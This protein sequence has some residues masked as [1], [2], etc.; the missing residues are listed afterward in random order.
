MA[1]KLKT[2]D[3]KKRYSLWDKETVINYINKSFLGRYIGTGKTAGIE[4]AGA[5]KRYTIYGSKKRE[6]LLIQMKEW[7]Q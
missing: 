6:L 7:Y 5:A 4:N 3:G 2:K 1:K